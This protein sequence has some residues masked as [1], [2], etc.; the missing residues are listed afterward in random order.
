MGLLIGKIYPIFNRATALVHTGEIVSGILFLYFLLYLNEISQL[1]LSS[2]VTY[3]DKEPSLRLFQFT[4]C[5]PLIDPN[6]VF[7]N[8]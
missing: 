8:L 4:S 1:G 7:F 6:D 3:C 5:L 2:K